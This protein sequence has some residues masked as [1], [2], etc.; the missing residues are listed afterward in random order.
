LLAAASMKDRNLICG[1]AFATQTEVAV[2][3]RRPPTLLFGEIVERYDLMAG[4][5]LA[6]LLALSLLAGGCASVPRAPFTEAE[7]DA[8]APSGLS[9]VRYWADAP[10][11]AFQN[12][13]RRA[14][15]QKGRPFTYLALSGGGGGGAYGAGVLNGWTEAGE[16]PEFTI[17]SGVSTGALIA[18][19]AFL[20]SAY[21]ETLK[22][23]YTSGQGEGLIE[24]ANPLGAI[25]G[26]GLVSRAPLRRLV[27]RYLSEDLLNAIAR[28]D[29]KGRRLLVVTTDLDAQRAVVWDMGAIAAAGGP[30]SFKLFRDVLAASASIPVVFAPQLIDVQTADR[31]FQEMHVDGTISAPIFTLPDAVLFGGKKVAAGSARPDLYVIVNSRID[32]GFEIVPNQAEAIA[33]HSFSTMNRIATKAVLAQT[34]NAAA[35]EGFRFHLSYIGKDHPESGGT[36]F[37]TA[38]MRALYEYGY[39]KA[40]AGSFWVT[41]LSQVEAAKEAAT[42]SR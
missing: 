16:R 32:P 42:A 26:N 22:Q 11:S 27:E 3:L 38:S 12:T 34:Y 20:G 15:P 6:I 28:E 1:N 13:K 30:Q 5:A 39:E 18:P 4:N 17:V 9:A 25:F 31:S 41:K 33:A 21:D 14:V 37:E 10:A 29:Q 24:Q 35:S 36:G 19:F 40:R 8:A 7:E 23:M 2:G